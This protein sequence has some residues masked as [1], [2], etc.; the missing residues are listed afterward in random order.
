MRLEADLNV[1]HATVDALFTHPGILAPFGL[2][3]LLDT[4]A[5][6]SCLLRDH[7][8][9]FG[10]PYQSLPKD[11]EPTQTAAGEVTPR[12]LPKVDIFLPIKDSEAEPARLRKFH[13]EEFQILPPPRGHNPE[14]RHRVVSVLG[15]DVL[16]RFT[17]WDWDWNSRKLILD[18]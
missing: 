7:V 16:R 1:F 6:R 11:R 10:I 9:Y 5:T 15:M 18:E 2:T 4:G 13:F 14:P 3:L 8:H 12:L 17:K